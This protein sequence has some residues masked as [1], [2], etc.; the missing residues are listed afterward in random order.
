M[1]K[2]HTGHRTKHLTFRLIKKKLENISTLPTRY[3]YCVLCIYFVYL[4]LSYLYAVYTYYIYQ[5]SYF[6]SNI[7]ISLMSH[8]NKT[9]ENENITRRI[10]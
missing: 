7:N 3:Y 4:L 10:S 1:P 6:T 5:K 9:S 8:H 2:R